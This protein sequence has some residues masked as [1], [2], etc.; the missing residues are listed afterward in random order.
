MAKLLGFLFFAVDK[1]FDRVMDAVRDH[2]EHRR[3]R[4]RAAYVAWLRSMDPDEVAKSGRIEDVILA[5][6]IR[7]AKRG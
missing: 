4:D 7:V 3:R 2:N 5:Q 6:Q 1:F